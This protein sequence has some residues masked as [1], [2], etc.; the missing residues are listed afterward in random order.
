M[1]LTGRELPPDGVP[2]WLLGEGDQL[3]S[4]AVV[5]AVQRDAANG[6]VRVAT[7]TQPYGVRLDRDEPV[8]VFRHA[9]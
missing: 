2:A 4:G 5:I 1:P 7:T 8:R 9:R 6:T 3:A